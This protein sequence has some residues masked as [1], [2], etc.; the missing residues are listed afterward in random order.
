M[1]PAPG[2]GMVPRMTERVID[3]FY[4]VGSSYS[5]L[6][7]TQ[8]ERIERESGWRVRHRPFLLGAVFKATGNTTPVSIA[9]KAQWMAKDMDR[10][11]KHYGVPFTIPSR[12]PAVTLATQRALCAAEVIG[13][14]AAL[15]ALTPR[16][17][18]A[19][20]AEDRDV[21][22]PEVIAECARAAGLDE[23]AILK[24]ASEAPAKDLL[25]AHTDAALAKGAFGAPCFVVGDELFW[26]NDRIPLL[27]HHL[28]AQA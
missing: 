20:W 23:A 4:D 15:R 1:T 8:I 7:S 24:G 9:A 16:L 22:S 28:A 17:M 12:F 2:R 19:F 13:G 11:A 27:L 3:F 21:A 26:G 18:R 6:A 5:Y 14:E 10:W 25:R